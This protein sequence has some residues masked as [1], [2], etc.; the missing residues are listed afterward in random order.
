LAKTLCAQ[1][2]KTRYCRAASQSRISVAI[3]DAEEQLET[4][5]PI[6]R[7]RGTADDFQIGNALLECSRLPTS[8]ARRR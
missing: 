7:A 6:L 4:P 5:A 3:A 1:L 8:A 2:A